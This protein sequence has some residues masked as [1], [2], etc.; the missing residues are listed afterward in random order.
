MARVQAERADGVNRC[1]C[2]GDRP[3]DHAHSNTEADR[4]RQKQKGDENTG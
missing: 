2:V 3:G 1:S 4:G